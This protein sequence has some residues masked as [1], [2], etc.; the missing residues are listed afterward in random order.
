MKVLNKQQIKASEQA[1]VDSGISYDELMERAGNAAAKEIISRFEV[2]DKIITIICGNGNN[3]GDG[4]V[5]ASALSAAKAKVKLMMPLGEPKTET[6]KNQYKLL[7]FISVEDKFDINCDIVIDALFGIGLDRSVTGKFADLINTVNNAHATRI[8]IDIPSG[9]FCN[10]GV[11]GAAVKAHLTLTMIAPKPCFYLPPSNE[12]CGEVVTLDIGAPVD[13][14]EYQTIEAP[15]FKKRPKNAHKGSSGS[16]LMLCGSYGMCGAQI[17]AAKAALR[18]GV[19]LIRAFVC[20]KNYSAFCTSVPEA[21]TIP[22][23]TAESCAPMV[24]KQLFMEKAEVSHAV[25]IGCGLGTSETV[26]D[27]IYQVLPLI[28]V[29]LILDADGINAICCDINIIRKIKVP[30]I[31]TPHPGEMARLCGTSIAEVEKDRIGYARKFATENSCILVLKGANTVI[32]SP[33][34]NVFFN[35][36]G[37]PGMATGGSGDVL[38][39]IMVAL[40]AQ[41]EDPLSAAK[42]AVFLHGAAGD[43]A[44][45]KRGEHSMLPSD[46]ID[47]L[48]MPEIAM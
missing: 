26:K 6:A 27:L 24:S 47:E 40:L 33:E 25:L 36:T 48:K 14:F 37:N 5:I 16:A 11:K 8:A 46:I 23:P 31:L 34:G 18:S 29:P 43:I 45:A 3:G 17:L 38:A 12:Y 22:V 7:P 9:V 13:D 21:V 20:D 30:V 15:I 41:G 28:K 4:F 35:T 42:A 2:E 19:G 32:A 39:G 1:A 10:G 44:A